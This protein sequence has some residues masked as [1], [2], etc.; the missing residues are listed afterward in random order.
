MITTSADWSEVKFNGTDIA[1]V[2]FNG[3]KVWE[4]PAAGQIFGIHWSNTSNSATRTDDAVGMTAT[5]YMAD[6]STPGSSSFDSVMPW[7]GM[8]IVEKRPNGSKFV[9]IP[10]FWF[11]IDTINQTIQIANYAADGFIVSPAH[12]ARDGH[13]ELDEVFIARYLSKNAAG[14]YES[15]SGVASSSL[16]SGNRATAR[17]GIHNLSTTTTQIWLMDIYMKITIDL[18]YLVEYANFDYLNTIGRGNI[19]AQTGLTDSMP[20]H[21][22]TVGTTRDAYAAS[23]YRYIELGGNQWLDGLVASN[24]YYTWTNCSN[25]ADSIS[26]TTNRQVIGTRTA[27]TSGNYAKELNPLF[28]LGDD[29]NYYLAGFFPHTFGS[30]S[31]SMGYQYMYGTPSITNL[32]GQYYGNLVSWE[33]NST[34]TSTQGARM[35]IL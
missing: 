32:A 16:Y 12:R 21:T 11:K 1:Q 25:Y 34:S 29:N 6:G 30:K 31:S 33:T 2:N 22:G 15:Q 19:D 27:R 9:K 8:T 28:V 3:V 10:K 18:L 14:G 13:G 23:Q 5:A 35:M 4:K 24:S 7:S 17:A 26:Q 20:F